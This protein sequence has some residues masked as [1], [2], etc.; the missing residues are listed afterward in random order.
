MFLIEYEQITASNWI[1][2]LI[3]VIYD[4]NYTTQFKMILLLNK[5]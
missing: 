5:C 3:N 2:M 4:Y 1:A